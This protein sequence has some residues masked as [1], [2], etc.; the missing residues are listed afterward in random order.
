MKHKNYNQHGMTFISLVVMFLFVGMLL[1][2]ILRIFPLYY[3]NMGLQNALT[4]FAQEYSDNSKMT[5]NQMKAGL[6]KRFDAQDVT[7]IT[8]KDVDF[9]RTKFGYTM[10]ASYQPVANYVGNLN[11]MLDFEHVIELEK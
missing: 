10:D 11:F 7:S 9:K 4:G 3:E 1:L 2:A 8:A 5:L 6:Q